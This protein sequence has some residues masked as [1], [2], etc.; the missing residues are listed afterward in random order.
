MRQ[1]YHYSEPQ[2]IPWVSTVEGQS[3]HFPPMEI[4]TKKQKFLVNL[5]AVG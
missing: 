5:K 1:I 4:G 2:L 3:G